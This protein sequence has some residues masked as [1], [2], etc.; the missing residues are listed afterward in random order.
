M[1]NAYT[2][3]ATL[4]E[5][6]GFNDRMQLRKTVTG[7]V[8]RSDGVTVLTGSTYF[9]STQGRRAAQAFVNMQVGRFRRYLT[10]NGECWYD[11]RQARLAWEKARDGVRKDTAREL[12]DIASAGTK[13]A[14]AGEPEDACPYA[15]D[16]AQGIIWTQAY[17]LTTDRRADWLSDNPQPVSE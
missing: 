4:R 2:Y 14:N 6:D 16:S 11:R 5:G 13:A 1:T 9:D 7:I 3:K 15:T 17:R 8:L 12:M 10:A